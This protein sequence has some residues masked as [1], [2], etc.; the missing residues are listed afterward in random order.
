[1]GPSL[2]SLLSLLTFSA[3]SLLSLFSLLIFSVF[4]LLSLL[5]LLV[6]SGVSL[7]SLASLAALALSWADFSL[8]VS[9]PSM[10]P[11]FSGVAGAAIMKMSTLTCTLANGDVLLV[12]NT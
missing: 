4:S 1:S 11:P 9:L 2:L 10:V 6:L 3:A 12:T 8:L 7:F 5:S